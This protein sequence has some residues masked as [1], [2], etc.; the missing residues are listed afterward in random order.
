MEG[1]AMAPTKAGSATI[2]RAAAAAVAASP[3]VS[4]PVSSTE[5][6]R[7]CPS[8]AVSNASLAPWNAGADRAAASSDERSSRNAT[9]SCTGKGGTEVEA[10]GR[11]GSPLVQLAR[12]ISIRPM[13]KASLRA[14][15][16]AGKIVNLRM[17]SFECMACTPWADDTRPQ[18]QPLSLGSPEV[19]RLEYETRP[20]HQFDHVSLLIRD[21]F[22]DE[23]IG[24]LT[25][26]PRSTVRDW[27]RKG[28]PGLRQRTAALDCPRC[29][30]SISDESAYAYLLGLYLGDG[31]ISELPRALRL[32]LVLDVRYPS[33]IQEAKRTI[34]AMHRTGKVGVLQ[35]AGCVEI[36]S[37]WQHWPCVFPQHGPGRKHLRR[38][39]LA[40]WQ[41]MITD[42]QAP[43]FLR[44]LIHSDGCRSLN[45]VNG[46]EYPRYIF[47][48]TSSDILKI[49]C[50]ACETYG[51]AFRRMRVE[52]YLGR[53]SSRR[54]KARPSHRSQVLNQPPARID[55]DRPGWRNQVDSAPSKGAGLRPVRV[56][57]P[58]PAQLDDV[59]L[60]DEV[61]SLESLEREAGDVNRHRLALHDHL[62]QE[63]PHDRRV[64]E[65]VPAEPT[66]QVQ[67]G[68]IRHGPDDRV[69][70]GS[71]LVEPCPHAGDPCPLERGEDPDGGRDQLVRHQRLVDRRVERRSLGGAAHPH[72][73]TGTL[74][75]EVESGVSVDHQ[76]LA[77]GGSREGPRHHDVAGYR[78][79]RQHHPTCLRQEAGPR[80]RCVH[81]HVGPDRTLARL[82]PPDPRSVCEDGAHVDASPRLGAGTSRDRGVPGRQPRG[83]GDPVVRAERRTDHPVQ[84]EARSECSR[85]LR[86]EQ[87]GVDSEPALELG[88]GHE[89]P[90]RRLAPDEEQVAVLVDV[91]RDAVRL[92]ERQDHRDARQGEPNVDLA[93]E[94][95]PEATGAGPGG[96]RSQG[97]LPFQQ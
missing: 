68:G 60:P 64:L 49:F 66:G 79:Q 18:C 53:A 71:H 91:E 74:A 96:A 57:I 42:R 56:R 88:C 81:D 47:T 31:C 80:P 2:S 40:P 15:A 30:G 50:D 63:L 13:R 14:L 16:E 87:P 67:A 77:V 32:R 6:G 35:R 38:I 8:A 61:A 94:L 27:R 29:G 82:D 65:P 10:P 43:C 20:G 1:A 28:R 17:V 73:D 78:L 58:P 72:Q 89:R 93:R 41:K 5:T 84:A 90:P 11:P 21:G 52:C 37:Y 26:I 19:S 76:R 7:P 36:S 34:G 86:L 51:V 70:V 23:R 39:E 12:A 83:I 97:V 25:G 92:P 95:V 54:H 69:S 59:S 22:G 44:G 46:G 55:L 4:T 33:I 9:F 24:A 75:M 62:G 85:L 48:N 3:P 45:R